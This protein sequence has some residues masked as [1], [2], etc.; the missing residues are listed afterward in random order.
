[1]NGINYSI[2]T[3]HTIVIIGLIGDARVGKDTLATHL[4]QDHGFKRLAFAD[5]IK[6]VAKALFQMTD[7]Q[8]NSGAKD[9]VDSRWNITPRQFF[10]QFGTDIMQRDI[11]KY[12]PML[13]VP[14]RHFWSQRLVKELEADLASGISKFVI[15]DIRFLHEYEDLVEL[16]TRL[17]ANA[18]VSFKTIKI[19]RN[20]QTTGTHVS[21]TEL[22]Q[23]PDADILLYNNGTLVEYEAQ[24]VSAI[25]G[26][27]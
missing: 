18:S 27:L 14:P 6:Q 5:P 3:I 7:E 13:S 25:S 12:L 21:Q 2:H 22:Q 11:Y 26:I 8:C 23:L 24:C 20:L 15:T 19:V 4:I 1:M 9:V 10:Q 17:E 16:K